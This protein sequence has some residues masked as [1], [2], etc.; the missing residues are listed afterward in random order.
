MMS[1]CILILQKRIQRAGKPMWMF[2]SDFLLLFLFLFHFHVSYTYR[3]LYVSPLIWF[4][5]IWHKRCTV[6]FNIAKVIFT[7]I[8]I[9]LLFHSSPNN[10]K[11]IEQIYNKFVIHVKIY[12]DYLLLY[13]A[14]Q[15]LTDPKCVIEN[16]CGNTKKN[17]YAK[18]KWNLKLIFRRDIIKIENFWYRGRIN[19]HGLGSSLKVNFIMLLPF[20]FSDTQ[21]E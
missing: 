9:R 5:S 21:L 4:L 8:F 20:L 12:I 1:H 3:I 13:S 16:K 19:Q 11:R 10:S 14:M 15:I 18:F 17:Y 6:M 2:V 7:H